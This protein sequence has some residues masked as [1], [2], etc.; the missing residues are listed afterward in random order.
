MLERI[1]RMRLE[2]VF[3]KEREK[4]ALLSDCSLQSSVYS[5]N[6]LG[7]YQINVSVN[8]SKCTSLK[9]KWEVREKDNDFSVHCI[10]MLVK[11]MRN[12]ENCG[13]VRKPKTGLWKTQNLNKTWRKTSL[14]GKWKI[15]C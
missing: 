4:I 9:L 3:D 8:L 12:V 15:N 6:L 2:S 7:M 5:I 14:Q 1:A 11:T 10:W 13:K